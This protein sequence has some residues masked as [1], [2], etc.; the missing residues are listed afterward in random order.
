MPFPPGSHIVFQAY[1]QQGILQECVF[2]LLSLSRQH[3][4][5]GLQDLEIWLYTDQKE[6]FE[7][8][9]TGLNL[10]FREVDSAL[11]KNWRGSIDFVHRVKIEVL[12][13]FVSKRSG[14]VLY[15]D[16]DVVIFSPLNELFSAIAQ[17]R[18]HMHIMEGRVHG[19]D[20]ILFRK[21][22][23]FLD[24]RPKDVTSGEF[25]I[26]RDIS[27][28]NAGVL[29]FHTRYSPLLEKVLDFTDKVY[30]AFPKHIV[31]QFA[32]SLYF[33]ERGETATIHTRIAHYWNLKEL[34][35]ILASFFSFFENRQWEELV[36]YSQL[37]QLQ[38]PMQEK[39][40]F[41]HNRTVGEKIAKKQWRPREPDWALLLKQL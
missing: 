37:I 8:F 26:P 25:T 28:W 35:T 11:I 16:T 18:L 31:E 29:G 40:N 5:E 13:D 20:N 38:E 15:L 4:Q 7:S 33:Q 21:L 14:Q 19:S 3:T 6:Y 24:T 1:G 32:F 2:A 17:G 34:R 22:S 27:M 30:P 10:H 39:I 12:R 36:H 23:K 41:L 9:K